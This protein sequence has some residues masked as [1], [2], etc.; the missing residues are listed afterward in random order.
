MIILRKYTEIHW[1]RL[2]EEQRT[3]EAGRALFSG[4]RQFQLEQCILDNSDDDEDDG[5]NEDDS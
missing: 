3:E 5:D 1:L 2:R 4:R